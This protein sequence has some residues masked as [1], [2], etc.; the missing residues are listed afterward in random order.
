MREILLGSDLAGATGGS[1]ERGRLLALL[2]ANPR[3]GEPARDHLARLHFELSRLRAEAIDLASRRIPGAATVH[4][5]LSLRREAKRLTEVWRE[6]SE[7]V[8]RC[9][10]P[11]PCAE[12]DRSA[13]VDAAARSRLAK[14]RSDVVG[15]LPALVESGDPR[16]RHRLR[17]LARLDAILGVVSS[18]PAVAAA[19]NFLAERDRRLLDAA[20]GKRVLRREDAGFECAPLVGWKAANLGEVARLAGP[21]RVPPWFAVTDAAFREALRSRVGPAAGGGERPVLEDAIADV[22][23]QAD[24]DVT[25]RSRA[26]AGLWA[27]AELPENVREEIERAYDSLRGEGSE[28]PFVAVRSSALGEDTETAA[29]AG[30]FDTFLFVRGAASVT[31]H[32]KRAWAGL[33]S[34]RAQDARAR[35]GAEASEAGGG[36]IVQR[37][38]DSRVSGV[39]QT[40]HAAASDA[41]EIVINAGLGLGEGIVSGVVGADQITIAREG[42]LEN[43]PL[44]FRYVIGDKA[45]MIV[46]DEARGT[47]THRVESRYHQRRRAALEYVE[48]LEIVGIATRLEA[49]YGYP[50]DIEFALE[51]D[52]LWVLQARP[53][54]GY[55][56]LEREEKIP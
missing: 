32:V 13:A 40:V 45:E 41:G 18:D 54:P 51:D 43:G 5:V 27:Q 6:A 46:R 14:I 55:V 35:D 16:L 2:L 19:R 12:N 9:G 26:I 10:L 48:L 29:R 31:E 23:A 49:A 24:R 52:R 8:V 47:G 28:D 11:L 17:T 34:A 33:W 53:V 36:V 20:R 50:L 3:V 7:A 56:A 37:M 42:D 1:P 30:E 38:V 22:L 15:I 4:E 25:A 21:E 44:R 39:V